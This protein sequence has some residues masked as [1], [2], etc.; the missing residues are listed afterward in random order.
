MS[1]KGCA[2]DIEARRIVDTRE[3][4]ARYTQARRVCETGERPGWVVSD[5]E[6][7]RNPGSTSNE[8]TLGNNGNRLHPI[9][10]SL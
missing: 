8:E 2:D 1:S 10:G 6:F 9:S 5:S 4:T 3:K 7:K